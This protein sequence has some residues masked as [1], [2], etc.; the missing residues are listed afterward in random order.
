MTPSPLA[1]SDLIAARV[2]RYTS[3]PTA[4][5]FNSTVTPATVKQWLGAIPGDQALSLYFHIPFCESLCWFCGCHTRV[6]NHYGPVKAYV[7]LLLKEI[8]LIAGQLSSLHDVSH[9][10]FGGGSPTMLAVDDIERLNAAI[11]TRFRVRADAEFAVEI[12]PR[13]LEPATIT[14]FAAAGANRASIGL[15]D[16]NP[17]V[18][19]AINRWQPL[20]VTR[21]AVER[22]R[23]AGIEA[24]NIDLMYGLPH[25]TVD[26]V[27]RT[28]DRA[29]ELSPQRLAVFGYAHVPHMK[30][31]QKLIDEQA[32]PTAED[33][34][35]Q[36]D[37]AHT[38]L[39][40]HDYQPIGLDHFALPSDPLAIAQR[41]G[42]LVRNFQGYTTD[43]APLIGIGASSISSFSQ[44][45]AQNAATVPDYRHSILQAHLAT[46]RGR[47]LT[48][49]D[50][51]RGEII[52]RLMCDLYVDLGEIAARHGRPFGSLTTELQMLQPFAD[53]GLLV[54]DDDRLLVPDRARAGVRLICAAFDQY[55]QQNEQRHAVAV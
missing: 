46:V 13:G 20:E 51:F 38:R 32:L 4:P 19:R 10:H 24:V 29:V 47:A 55:L 31:H 49:E 22:L 33:R 26:D 14:A 7:D 8:D 27:R 1:R 9:I 50:R 36:Y 3:Y 40:A 42:R 6:V 17:A 21:A 44:G 23:H 12:D 52:E 28:V 43:H 2:P 37:T 45:Y 5:H 54:I 35:R 30:S 25:Q 11:R 39:V 18:Q 41:Q 48:N 53:Q 16:V 15:Q 34:L